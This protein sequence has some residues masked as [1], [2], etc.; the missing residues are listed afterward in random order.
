MPKHNFSTGSGEDSLLA[1]LN[2]MPSRS[3]LLADLGHFSGSSSD[4]RRGIPSTR[5]QES[6]IDPLTQPVIGSSEGQ[7]TGSLAQQLF[8]QT[9]VLNNVIGADMSHSSGGGSILGDI[10]GFGGHSS[11]GILGGILGNVLGGGLPG[12]I[13]GLI[14]IFGGGNKTPPPNL[15]PFELPPPVQFQGGI[16]GPGGGGVT[17][18]D[19]GQ[20]GAPR[21]AGPTNSGQ[22]PA[23][24]SQQITIQV[25]A[26][27]SKSFLDH[28]DD[29]AR[30]VRQAMLQSNSLNDVVAGI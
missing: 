6:L 16:D 22:G 2:S 7:T 14:D 8:L 19:F 20:N 13:G 4:A 11:S 17:A 24:G 29:I 3:G 21:T 15:V 27:D 1:I 28:S 26:M 5:N 25:N 12:L 9:Q 18:V 10:F 30:A 23:G